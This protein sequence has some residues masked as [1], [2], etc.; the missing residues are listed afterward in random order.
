MK[1][2]LTGEAPDEPVHECAACGHAYTGTYGRDYITAGGSRWLCHECA[3][4]RRGR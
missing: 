2:I 1:D 4:I 3:S